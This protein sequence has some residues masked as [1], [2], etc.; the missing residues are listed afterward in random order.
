MKIYIT[1]LAT[2]A[3]LRVSHSILTGSNNPNPETPPQTGED[4]DDTEGVFDLDGAA[5]RG[6]IWND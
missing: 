3:E 4:L 2:T 1:P 5:Y 6:N